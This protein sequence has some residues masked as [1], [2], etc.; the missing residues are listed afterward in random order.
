MGVTIQFWK[1]QFS[2]QRRPQD[3]RAR[4]TDRP[5]DYRVLKLCELCGRQLK[6]GTKAIHTQAVHPEYSFTTEY[7]RDAACLTYRCAVCKLTCGGVVGIIRH[8]RARHPEKLVG[9]IVP[10]LDGDGQIIE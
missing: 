4:K 1:W 2:I 5:F 7:V 10:P 8:Y 3:K 9:A 6:G